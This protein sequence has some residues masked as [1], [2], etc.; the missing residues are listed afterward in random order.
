MSQLVLPRG[1]QRRPPPRP[2]VE[3]PLPLAITEEARFLHPQGLPAWSGRGAQRLGAQQADGPGMTS[4]GLVARL[5]APLGLGGQR[6]GFP[7]LPSSGNGS[8]GP[9]WAVSGSPPLLG[10]RFS[11]PLTLQRSLLQW[12]QT[13]GGGQRADSLGRRCSQSCWRGAAGTRGTLWDVSCP[14]WGVGCLAG[15]RTHCGRKGQKPG[16]G[17]LL[18]CGS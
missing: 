12:D 5:E 14:T 7:A 4:R 16:P 17:G 8:P 15:P 10:D 3:S 11:W 6:R 9:A 13:G 2:P 18:P 1:K